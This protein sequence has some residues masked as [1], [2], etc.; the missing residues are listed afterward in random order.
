[1]NS[2]KEKIVI[3]TL[4]KFL[5]DNNKYKQ[6]YNNL[7]IYNL[8]IE[9]DLNY[10]LFKNNLYIWSAKNLLLFNLYYYNYCKELII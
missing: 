10:L 1:M 7:Y 9:L 6:N 8:H 2:I 3:Y 4:T 5:I